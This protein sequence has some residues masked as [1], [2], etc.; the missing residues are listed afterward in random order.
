MNY[1]ETLYIIHPALDAGRVKEMVLSVND[2]LEKNG[3]PLKEPTPPHERAQDSW[4]PSKVVARGRGS[5]WY[6]SH[7][8]WWYSRKL[9]TVFT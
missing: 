6:G 8:R 5:I 1:Y 7:Y 4:D 3:D 2:T 9:T